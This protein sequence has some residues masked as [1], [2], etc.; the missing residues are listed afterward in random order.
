MA[1]QSN[2]AVGTGMFNRSSSHS[3]KTVSNDLS[4][5]ENINMRRQLRNQ[6]KAVMMGRANEAHD[7]AKTLSLSRNATN[8]AIKPLVRKRTAREFAND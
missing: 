5:I 8:K 7:V 6:Q 1:I 3:A 4:T 2:K